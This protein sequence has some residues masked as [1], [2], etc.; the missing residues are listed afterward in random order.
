M[1]QSALEEQI[2]LEKQQEKLAVVHFHGVPFMK[3]HYTNFQRR[4]V[5][6]KIQEMNKPLTKSSIVKDDK[7]ERLKAIHSRNFHCH[8][9]YSNAL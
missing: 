3:G 5:G 2:Q 8:S 4:F 1:N 7:L 9:R 6:R